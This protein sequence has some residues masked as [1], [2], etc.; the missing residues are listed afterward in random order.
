MGVFIVIVR[1]SKM[2][3]IFVVFVLTN[4]AYASHREHICAGCPIPISV[5]RIKS[6][7]KIMAALDQAVDMLNAKHGRKNHFRL[8]RHSILSGTSQIV[9]G[10]MYRVKVKMVESECQNIEENEGKGIERCPAK[11][12][13]TTKFCTVSLWS[14]PWLHKSVV[15]ISC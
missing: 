10:V 6:D 5:S 1:A 11:S 7:E 14:R 15:K 13:G 12:S 9:A 4:L 8:V 2:L 3:S